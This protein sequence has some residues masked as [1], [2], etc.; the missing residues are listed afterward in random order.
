MQTTVKVQNIRMAPRKLRLVADF[1]R[2]MK[3]EEA[4]QKLRWLNKIG[5]PIVQKAIRS[6]IANAEHNFE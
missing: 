5:S 4:L 1:V 6:A 3:V 2:K